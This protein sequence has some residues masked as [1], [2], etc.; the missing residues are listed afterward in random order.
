MIT[1]LD[2]LSAAPFEARNFPDSPLSIGEIRDRGYA[3]QDLWLPT[4][5]ARESSLVHN[6]QRFAAWC[7]ERDVLLAP[8]GKTSMSP[9]LW[10]RQLDAG[11]WGITAATVAQARVMDRFGV[12]RVIIANEVVDPDQALWIAGVNMAIDRHYYLLVDSESC[13]RIIEDAAA[14]VGATVPVLIEFGVPGGRTGMR[15][16][17]EV[18]NLGR[19]VAQSEHLQLA[20]LEGYEGALPQG[21]RADAVEEAVTWLGRLADL[22]SEM[23]EVGLFNGVDTILASAGGSGYPDLAADALNSI[24]ET[25]RP[26]CRIIRS[27]AYL[28]HDHLTY[29]RRSPLRSSADDDPLVPVLTCFAR[30]NSIPEQGLVLVGAGKRDVPFDE[31]LPIILNARDMAGHQRQHEGLEVFAINDHHLYVRDPGS[32]LA[33]GDVLELGLSHPCTTFDKWQ[34]IPV[35]DAKDSV[36]DALVTLF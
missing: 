4:L 27:G 3:L 32:A 36:V 19:V 9:Q 18:V 21:R 31:D 26:V 29:E 25:S 24:S 2:R 7:R 35:L 20:G 6:L 11:A 13:V 23:D 16:P 33:V 10:Q 12:E 15:S 22:V 34:M 5:V 14:K 1:S 17:D 8:H 28:T 30:V